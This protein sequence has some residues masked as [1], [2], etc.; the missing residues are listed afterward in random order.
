M[1]F[2]L[3]SDGAISTAYE[4]TLPDLEVVYDQD[5]SMDQVG[6][7]RVKADFTSDAGSNSCVVYFSLSQEI[8]DVSYV[9]G[10]TGD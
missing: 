4:I 3:S 7:Y 1:R 2:I 5:I 9:I 8:D 6:E 10:I